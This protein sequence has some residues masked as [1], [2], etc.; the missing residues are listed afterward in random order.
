MLARARER[1]GVSQ[2]RIERSVERTIRRASAGVE[3]L[4]ARLKALSPL[5]VLDRG[6]ALVITESGAVIRS[7]SQV[8][9]G[10][11]VR[12]RLT[13]GEFGSTVDDVGEKAKS[14]E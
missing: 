6:Y 14:A 9:K 12:T 2:T 11:R 8:R 10:E 13:D 7:A 4:D 5:A 1:L 3:A